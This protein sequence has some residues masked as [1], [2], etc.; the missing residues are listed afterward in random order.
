[1]YEMKK[2]R[3]DT[4]KHTIIYTLKIPC[5]LIKSLYGYFCK[6]STYSD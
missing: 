4:I 1:M 6:N 5:N 3:G 2:K